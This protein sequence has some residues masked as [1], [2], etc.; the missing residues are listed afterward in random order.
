MFCKP[1]V[2]V[3]CLVI[4]NKAI[5]AKT[6]TKV[7]F[8]RIATAVIALFTKK[9]GCN[10]LVTYFNRI[11]FSIN[12]NAFTYSYNFTCTFVTKNNFLVAERI[13]TIFVNVCTTDTTTFNLNKNFTG[14]R[15][16]DFDVSQL[17]DSFAFNT[18]NDFWL[19]KISHF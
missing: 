4:F 8:F 12:S 1:S 6:F 15:C 17:N 7:W 9:N 5:N 10:N 19:Y 18:V 16:R 3:M 14:T 2:I 11:T 13:I